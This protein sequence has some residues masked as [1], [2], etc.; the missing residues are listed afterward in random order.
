MHMKLQVLKHD[1]VKVEVLYRRVFWL[2]S[3]DVADTIFYS[4]VAFLDFVPKTPVGRR[5]MSGFGVGSK[6]A[7]RRVSANR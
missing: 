5:P 1:M 6:R 4:Y 2:N 7:G 3:V